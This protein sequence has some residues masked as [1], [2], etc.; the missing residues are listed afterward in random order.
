[1]S[2]SSLSGSRNVGWRNVTIGIAITMVLAASKTAATMSPSK[3]KLA[4]G[5]PPKRSSAHEP[6]KSL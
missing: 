5:L 2:V 4:T 3:R 6:S 1:M